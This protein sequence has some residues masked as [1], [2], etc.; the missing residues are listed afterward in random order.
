MKNV[1]MRKQV[2]SLVYIFIA[3]SEKKINLQ[4]DITQEK[5]N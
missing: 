1:A 5:Q 3:T 2:P 4:R